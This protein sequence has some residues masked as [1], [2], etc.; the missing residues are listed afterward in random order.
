M[1]LVYSLITHVLPETTLVK[2]K[3]ERPIKDRHISHGNVNL[4]K[5]FYTKSRLKKQAY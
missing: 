4:D 3:N 1:C 5:D 2:G